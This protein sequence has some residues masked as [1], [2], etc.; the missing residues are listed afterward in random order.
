M[1]RE[2]CDHLIDL[3]DPFGVVTAKAMFGGYGLY[4]QGQIFGIVVEDAPYFKVNDANRAEYESAGSEPFTYEAKGKRVT[5]SYWQVPLDILDD[6]D[7]LCVW[8]EKAYRAARQSKTKK[9]RKL[10]VP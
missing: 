2:Y 4:R 3:L 1:S 9:R 6:A 10:I 7:V 8:A 5:M